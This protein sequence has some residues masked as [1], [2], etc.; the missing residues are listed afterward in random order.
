MILI[1]VHHKVRQQNTQFKARAKPKIVH[2]LCSGLFGSRV[3]FGFGRNSTT[4]RL[5]GLNIF[6]SDF[7]GS[8]FGVRA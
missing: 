8:G 6:A 5:H 3:F 1:T 7:Y 2:I 4:L